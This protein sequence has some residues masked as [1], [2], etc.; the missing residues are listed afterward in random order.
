MSKKR[1]GRKLFGL[2]VLGSLASYVA[3]RYSKLEPREVRNTEKK[4][5]SLNNSETVISTEENEEENE[6]P[7]SHKYFK[8]LSNEFVDNI[9]AQKINI[10]DEFKLNDEVEVLHHVIMEMCDTNNR[11]IQ[12]NTENNYFLNLEDESEGLKFSRVVKVEN[13]DS[14]IDEILTYANKC[15][16]SNGTY[17]GYSLLKK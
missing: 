12:Y 7:D 2:A 11:F 14:I 8:Y 1:T 13:D 17:Q 10:N 16:E 9:K 6:D 3:Y 15:H 5:I 4:L